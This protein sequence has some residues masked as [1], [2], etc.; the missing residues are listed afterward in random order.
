MVSQ[1]DHTKNTEKTTAMSYNTKQK[2][3][4][5]K[6]FRHM[7]CRK[8]KIGCPGEV[9]EPTTEKKCYITKFLGYV[10]GLSPYNNTPELRTTDKYLHPPLYAATLVPPL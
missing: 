7:Y 10:S 6:I 4:F 9:T 2:R 8:T 3:K 1:S 5:F